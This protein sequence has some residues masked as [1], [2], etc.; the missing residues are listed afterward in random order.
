MHFISRAAPPGVSASAQGIYSSVAMG[1]VP[2]LAMLFAGRLYEVAGGGAFLA[3][4]AM[5][6]ASI[7]LSLR[8]ARRWD[9][10][11]VVGIAR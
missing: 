1:V 10:G 2:G 6:A 5:S 9:G 7:A 11:L 4:S 3:M 8:L